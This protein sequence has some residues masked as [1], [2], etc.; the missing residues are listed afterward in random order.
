MTSDQHAAHISERPI[1]VCFI[2]PKA[3]PLFNPSVNAIFGGAEVDVSLLAREL[4]KDERFDVACITA[5]YGQA[6][7]ERRDGVTLLKSLNF[8]HS[9]FSQTVRLWRTMER[10]SAD[11]Y[12][13]KTASP[14]TFLT[15]LFCRRRGKFFIYRSSHTD[16][17]DG[18]YLRQHPAAGRM[19]RWALRRAERVIVQN[20]SDITNLNRTTGVTAEAI[21]NA[22]QIPD[23]PPEPLNCRNILWIGRSVRMKQPEKFLQLAREISQEN[24]VMICPR[25]T[26]DTNYDALRHQAERIGNLKFIESVP[27]PQIGA[28]FQSAKVFVS[29]SDAEGFPNVFIQAGLWG[30]P[31]LSLNVNPDHFLDRFGCGLCAEGDWNTFVSQ[32]RRLIQPDE[33]ARFGAKCRKYVEENHKIEKNIERYKQ[34]FLEVAERKSHVK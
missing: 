15:A 3:Y 8:G 7:I 16:E 10:A 24:F 5:D 2:M 31:I 14:G 11:I 18:T 1:T 12:I 22:H 4:A 30:T 26:G 20:Q 33:M 13:Q 17:C 9:I 29:T 21:P 6:D 32:F 27:F 28:Y 25:G 23:L 34:I 19:F